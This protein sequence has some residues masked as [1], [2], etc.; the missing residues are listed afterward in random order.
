MFLERNVN[1]WLNIGEIAPRI[2]ERIGN[3]FIDNQSAGDS[4]LSI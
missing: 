1:F 4:G 3:Y 2:F